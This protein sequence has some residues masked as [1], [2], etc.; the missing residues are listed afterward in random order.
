[1]LFRSKDW[2]PDYG[3]WHLGR[4]LSGAI[5]GLMTVILLSA[6]GATTQLGNPAAVLAIAF[7]F[8]TQ[9]RRFFNFLY[10]VARLIVTV[11]DDTQKALSLT[12]IEPASAPTGDV[13]IVKGAGI[14]T[15]AT[16]KLGG[17]PLT[18]QRI[19]ADGTSVAGEVPVRPAGADLVDVTVTN[20]TGTSFTL[21][22]AFT[23]SS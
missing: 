15:G 9:E 7:I 16:V 3:L 21:P 22:N 23:F 6:A 8:G 2:D 18:K 19:A 14:D 13:V 1:M 12:G 4:P 17:A 11:P 5:A 10:E 20:G